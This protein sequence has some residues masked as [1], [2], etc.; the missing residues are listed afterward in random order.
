MT[1]EEIYKYYSELPRKNRRIIITEHFNG[2]DLKER[3]EYIKSKGFTYIDGE[4]IL[5]PRWCAIDE[6]RDIRFD[7]NLKVHWN[8]NK[9]VVNKIQFEKI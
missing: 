6:E 8:I 7:N 2:M 1:C 3:K 5:N 9:M 4:P